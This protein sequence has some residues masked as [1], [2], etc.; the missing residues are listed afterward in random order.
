MFDGVTD[1]FL[2][3]N[4]CGLFTPKF[5]CPKTSKLPHDFG[6]LRDLIMNIFGTPNNIINWKTALQ[7]TDTPAQA[8]LTWFTL[9]HK[10]LKIGPEF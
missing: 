8:K 2:V 5:D 9:V 4:L 6:Q 1:L 10:R 3:G 7:T